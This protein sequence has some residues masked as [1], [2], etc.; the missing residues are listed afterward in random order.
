MS[1]VKIKFL[2]RGE[3]LPRLMALTQILLASRADV[4]EVSLF[5]SLTRGNYV[6]GSD[7]DVYILLK[8]DSRRFIDR[9]PEFLKQFSGTGIPV[10]VFP[11]TLEEVKEI[12]DGGFIKA[13]EKEKIL[14]G[15]QIRIENR[16]DL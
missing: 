1:G 7:A 13:I 6:P 9:I 8:D 4:L 5:G 16:V 14:L 3:I 2:N 12:R 10:E 15:E 11:Y